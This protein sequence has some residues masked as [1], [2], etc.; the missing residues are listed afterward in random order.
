MIVLQWYRTFFRWEEIKRSHLLDLLVLMSLVSGTQRLKSHRY[1]VSTE[2]KNTRSNDDPK[3]NNREYR[4]PASREC[5][6]GKM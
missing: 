4:I 1:Q 5:H 6:L 2:R 3:Q